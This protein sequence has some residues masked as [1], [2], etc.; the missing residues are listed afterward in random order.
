MAQSELNYL[1]GTDILQM[2]FDSIYYVFFEG[3][4]NMALFVS[5]VS[6]TNLQT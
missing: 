6:A 1:I 4:A 3:I 2:I 5:P